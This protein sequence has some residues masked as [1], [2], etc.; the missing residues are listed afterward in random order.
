MGLKLKICWQ[1]NKKRRRRCRTL[2]RPDIFRILASSL[3]LCRVV[4]QLTIVASPAL[5]GTTYRTRPDIPE[6]RYV[7]V[8]HVHDN[9]QQQLGRQVQ[10]STGHSLLCK[11]PV[12]QDA[13]RF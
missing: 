4:A 10:Q 6:A 11:G 7:L 2:P 12:S 5:N 3:K 8:I 13:L 9:L 1:L